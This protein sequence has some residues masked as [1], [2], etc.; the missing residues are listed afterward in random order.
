M[1]SQKSRPFDR[2]EYPPLQKAPRQSTF[3]L[4]SGLAGGFEKIDAAE[5]KHVHGAG[6]AA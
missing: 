2:E 5:E 6:S 1:R 4:V 3:A